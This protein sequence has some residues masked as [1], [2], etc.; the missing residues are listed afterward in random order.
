MRWA[1]IIRC[2]ARFGDFRPIRAEN[3]CEITINGAFSLKIS[4]SAVLE[5]WHSDN[6]WQDCCAT[7]KGFTEHQPLHGPPIRKPSVVRVFLSCAQKNKF[8]LREQPV[9]RRHAFRG[10]DAFRENKT[11][12]GGKGVYSRQPKL[13]P[14]WAGAQQKAWFSV[15]EKF[16]T[17]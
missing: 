12:G 11:P 8:P 7:A 1:L 2:Y 16:A 5:W 9:V 4:S 15:T 6:F 14:N 13:V 10:N 3:G 17:G